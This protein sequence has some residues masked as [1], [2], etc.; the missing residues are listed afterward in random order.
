[1]GIVQG[2][3][4][5]FLS[6]NRA[7]AAEPR[8]PVCWWVDAAGSGSLCGEPDPGSARRSFVQE[9]ESTSAVAVAGGAESAFLTY[10][11]SQ[12]TQRAQRSSSVSRV[13]GP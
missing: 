10:R 8:Y 7:P 4:D 6:S 3:D 11:S 12:A 9:P 13:A 1:M 5:R 2:R